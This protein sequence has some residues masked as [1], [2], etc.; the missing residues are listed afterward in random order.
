MSGLC[1]VAGCDRDAYKRG[2]CNMHYQRWRKHGDLGNSH[3]IKASKGEPLRYLLEHMRDGC[4]YPWPYARH[5]WGYPDIRGDGSRPRLGHQIVCEAVYGP[6]PEEGMVVRHLCGKGH[7]GCFNAG[8]LVWGW[9]REN[10]KDSIEHGTW[11]HGEQHGN[12][13]VS[14]RSIEQLRR[15]YDNG[16]GGYLQGELAEIFGISKAQVNRIVNL[17]VRRDG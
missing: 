3:T 9:Q 14:T 11:T 10:V 13:V 17:K 15:L 1:L 4:C 6:P 7:L 2:W 12:T 5:D 8:C 16:K